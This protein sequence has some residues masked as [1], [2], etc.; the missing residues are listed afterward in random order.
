M[1]RFGVRMKGTGPYAELLRA[2]FELAARKLG[3]IPS[4]DRHE[5]DTS[6]FRP[7]AP[8]AGADDARLLKRGRRIGPRSTQWPLRMQA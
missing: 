4:G 2:R 1:R 8:G 7:P 5:L 6:L 3:L